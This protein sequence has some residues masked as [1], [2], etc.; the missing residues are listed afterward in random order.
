MTSRALALHYASKGAFTE[1]LK[2]MET[3]NN[4]CFLYT[5]IQQP[6]NKYQSEEKEWSVQVVVS[7]EEA[8]AWNKKFP[9]QKAKQFDNDEFTE[10]FD[11]DPP[12]KNQDEQFTI[13]LARGTAYKDGN[14][15]PEKYA[16][17]VYLKIGNGKVQDITKTKLVA[18]GST[19]KAA[20][21]VVENSFGT[22]AKLN[23]ICVENLIEYIPAGG[24]GSPFGTV[25]ED[26]MDA[27]R[28]ETFA[29][30]NAPAP[31]SGKPA[32]KKQPEPEAEEDFDDESA[33]F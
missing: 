25:V 27:E 10:K 31:K 21:D 24:S 2:S 1:R 23:S 6:K 17:K 12:F 19:G 33:P 13:K 5:N 11:I 9:K 4:A 16:P 32:A 30:S 20:Y 26:E 14:P 18:N 7:K 3:I 15:I 22:F 8:K 28:Q 29:A